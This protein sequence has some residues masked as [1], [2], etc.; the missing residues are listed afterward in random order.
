MIQSVLL[1]AISMIETT[2]LIVLIRLIRRLIRS[3]RPSATG[4]VNGDR[5][6]GY[7]EGTMAPR[8]ITGEFPIVS[9]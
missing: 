7:L 5:V 8:E 4:R 3:L 6:L 2:F 1:F 9:R